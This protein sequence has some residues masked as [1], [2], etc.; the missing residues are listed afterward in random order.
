M[1]LIWYA[2]HSCE[3]WFAYWDLWSWALILIF[4]EQRWRGLWR[5]GFE[6]RDDAGEWSRCLHF[7]LRE[8][9]S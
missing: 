1:I 4:D 7:E 9:C 2:Q 5:E 6:N 3:R 8:T